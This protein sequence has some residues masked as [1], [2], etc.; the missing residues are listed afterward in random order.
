PVCPPGSSSTVDPVTRIGV[1][2]VAEKAPS[3]V[4][5]PLTLIPFGSAAFWSCAF[6]GGPARLIASELA[7]TAINVLVIIGVLLRS[8]CELLVADWSPRAGSADRLG[9]RKPAELRGG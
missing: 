9:A 1:F 8:R 5:R 2:T 7:A 6:A 4:T 3:D